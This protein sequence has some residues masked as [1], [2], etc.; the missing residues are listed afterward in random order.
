MRQ[1][2]FFRDQVG[3]VDQYLEQLLSVEFIDCL[4][5]LVGAVAAHLRLH[6]SF[7]DHK[8]MSVNSPHDFSGLIRR[9]LACSTLVQPKDLR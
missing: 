4:S 8:L 6:S 1:V 2:S 9:R 5:L 3:D 7:L